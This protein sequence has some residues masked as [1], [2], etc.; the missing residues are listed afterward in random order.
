MQLVQ[1]LFYSAWQFLIPRF[2]NQTGPFLHFR[3]EVY[4]NPDLERLSGSF[5]D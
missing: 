3:T 4:R 1:F 5:R 2:I